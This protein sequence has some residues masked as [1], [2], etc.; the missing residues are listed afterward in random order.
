MIYTEGHALVIAYSLFAFCFTM[1]RE[2]IKDMEDVKGD[3]TFG[4]RTLPLVIGIR[5]TKW[6]IYGL[7]IVFVTVLVIL[8]FI[9]VG[10]E[11]AVFS[12]GLIIPLTWLLFL[13]SRADTVAAFRRLSNYCKVIMLAGIL[14]M[15]LF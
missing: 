7:S 13:L 8:S 14:S 12:A 3:A 6:F 4:C 1:I 15:V 11:L 5:K 9:F 10:R 2:V